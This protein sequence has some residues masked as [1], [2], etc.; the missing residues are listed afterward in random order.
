VVRR[1]FDQADM[2]NPLVCKIMQLDAQH[3]LYQELDILRRIPPH[4]HIVSI[5]KGM[6]SRGNR[7]YIVMEYCEDNLARTLLLPHS[8][9]Q[10]RQLLFEVAQGYLA[11]LGQDILHGDIKPSNI[12]I[13]DGRYKLADFGLSRVVK[14]PFCQL[15]HRLG[16]PAYMPPEVKTRLTLTRN[17]DIYSLGVILYRLVYGRLPFPQE[18]LDKIDYA[19]P[20][21]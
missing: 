13:K 1:V 15:K 20:V 16:T 14:G 10:I 3:G 7:A 2:A 17:S 9:S 11:L 18:E 12:L 21:T 19:C 5:V 4:P 8:D 6:A